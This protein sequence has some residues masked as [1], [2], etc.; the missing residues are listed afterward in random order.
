M[1]LPARQQ[2]VL[3][4]QHRPPT[5]EGAEAL[6]LCLHHKAA[7]H[8]MGIE[9]QGHFIWNSS[10]LQ[11]SQGSIQV[12]ESTHEGAAILWISVDGLVQGSLRDSHDTGD[13]GFQVSSFIGACRF[14]TPVAN[15]APAMTVHAEPSR[16]IARSNEAVRQAVSIRWH[17][18]LRADW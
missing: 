9:R 2:E 17:G 6:S 16:C 18:D 5:T 11:F 1:V 3:D 4:L 12:S 8:D 13:C 10:C 7:T 15:E 14:E